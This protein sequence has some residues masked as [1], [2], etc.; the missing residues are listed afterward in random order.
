MIM[1]KITSMSIRFIP[2][3]RRKGF[4]NFLDNDNNKKKS[5]NYSYVVNRNKEYESLIILSSSNC[6]RMGPF[7][8]GKSH[9]VRKESIQKGTPIPNRNSLGPLG[10]KLRS[11]IHFTI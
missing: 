9:T 4:N 7:N 1:D 5:R 2:F 11:F 3:I 10:F 8:D 6:S